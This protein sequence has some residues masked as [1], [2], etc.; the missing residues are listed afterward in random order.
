MEEAPLSRSTISSSAAELASL[1]ETDLKEMKKIKIG[2]RRILIS[3]ISNLKH[4]MNEYL[5]VAKAV[6]L[7]P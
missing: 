1:S 5:P 3:A 2:P 6:L 7:N 4:L